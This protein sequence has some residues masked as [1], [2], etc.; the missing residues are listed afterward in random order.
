MFIVK[1][2]ARRRRV[3]AGSI[4]RCKK[5]ACIIQHAKSLQTPSL[6]SSSPAAAL[7]CAAAACHPLHAE[8]AVQSV[9]D[10]VEQGKS[11][12]EAQLLRQ[13]VLE[14]FETG[15]LRLAE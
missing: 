3:G 9:A 8:H 12:Q 13:R 1:A 7:A 11:P 6:A 5:M 4:H 10:R 14:E 2:W 15:K